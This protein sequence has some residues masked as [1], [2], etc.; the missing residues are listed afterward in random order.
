MTGRTG[1]ATLAALLVAPALL[2][3]QP[4]PQHPAVGPTPPQPL[5]PA[6]M[7]LSP[8]PVEPEARLPRAEEWQAIDPRTVRVIRANGS[9]QVYTGGALF[10]DYG[11]D[12]ADANEVAKVLRDLHVTRWTTIGTGRTVVEYGLSIDEFGRAVVPP[13]VG[14]PRQTVPIDLRTVRAEQ[15][16][17]A[18]C[19][20]DDANILLNFGPHKADAAQAAGVVRKYGFNR[21][22]AAGRAEPV[23][24]Y[25]FAQPDMTAAAP[26]AGVSAG[27][28]AAAQEMALTRTGIEVPGVG[29]VGEKVAIDPRGVEARRERGEWV[30][31]AGREVLGRFGASEWAARDAVRVVQECRFT[32][33][34][35][36]GTAGVTFFLADGQAPRQVPYFAQGARFNP[37]GLRVREM[38]GKW[39]VYDG[40]GR[41]LLP[42]GSADEAGQLVALVK[43]YG[44]DQLCQVGTSPRASLKFLAK[45]R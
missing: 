32:E 9:W 10:R 26:P 43:A 12:P 13:V 33:F 30:V 1:P 5:P 19:L 8:G 44:F 29:Y 25:F 4:L 41:A 24:T 18:W 42:A 14:L 45:G 34:C 16:R 11:N 27:L 17:G 15:V 21:L 20:R 6:V 23:L 35:R 28:S 3:Q 39:W 38:A 2:A 40:G 22:G 37:A 36:F 31:A 7:Q